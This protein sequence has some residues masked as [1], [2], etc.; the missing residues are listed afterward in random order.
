M[1]DNENRR[2]QMFVRVRDF[3]VAHADDFTQQSL[4]KQ[5][6][7][8]LGA[9]ITDL[10]TH[11]GA[12]ASGHGE[13]RHGTETRAQ[14]RAALRESLDAISRTARA[15]P[16]DVPDA[17]ERFRVP[18]NTNDQHLLNAARA[19]MADADP[20]KAQFIAHELPARF[21]EDLQLDIDALEAAISV[22]G[23]GVGDHVA[24]GAA[25]DDT[26]DRGVDLVRK[27]GAIVRNKYVNNPAVLAEWTSA[28]HTERAPRH[29]VQP[30]P[31]SP[32]PPSAPSP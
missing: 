17:L 32:T 20:L 5:Y 4:G 11:A 8:D 18:R 7:T 19:F 22:Q 3:G 28:S 10:D 15:M 13:R 9:V 1:N 30:P 16:A 14:A 2:H 23:S 27:L 26:I 25:I 29:V 31:P 21:L 12:E 6:F 24:A